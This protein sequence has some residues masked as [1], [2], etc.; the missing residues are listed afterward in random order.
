[1]EWLQEFAAVVRIDQV[2]VAGLVTLAV[3]Y[4]FRGLLVPKSVVDDVRSERD[5]WKQAYLTEAKAGT[6]KD[7]QINELMEV[8]RTAQHMYRQLPGGE[9]NVAQTTQPTTPAA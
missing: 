6:V 5:A 4:I 8:A 2:A 1:M 9:G 7:G 3:I